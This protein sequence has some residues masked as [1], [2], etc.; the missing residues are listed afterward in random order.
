MKKTKTFSVFF[1]KQPLRFNGQESYRRTAYSR[2][3]R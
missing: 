2:F 3:A 1:S